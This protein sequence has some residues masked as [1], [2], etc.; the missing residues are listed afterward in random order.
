MLGIG[1]SRCLFWVRNKLPGFTRFGKN[2]YKLSDLLAFREEFCHME[3]VRA[4]KIKGVT[5]Q[6][7]GGERY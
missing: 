3:L 5:L 1:T 4:Y 7:L 2:F 6:M